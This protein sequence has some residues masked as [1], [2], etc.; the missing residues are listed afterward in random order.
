MLRHHGASVGSSASSMIVSRKFLA[1]S[2]EIAE[3]ISAHH[4]GLPSALNTNFKNKKR[5]HVTK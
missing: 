5:H 1:V 3:R 4:W 2:S